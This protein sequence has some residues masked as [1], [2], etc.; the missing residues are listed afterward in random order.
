MKH[1]LNFMNKINFDIET[2]KIACKILEIKENTD[3]EHVKKAY[4]RAAVKYHP[5]H[6]SNK[7]E[8]NKRFKLIKCA[9]ELLAFDKPCD[10]IFEESSQ[11]LDIFKG[12]K[13]NLENNWGH[14]L[15]WKERFHSSSND[16]LRNNKNKYDKR[17]S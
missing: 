12:N 9:Y 7:V 6:S 3:I 17:K 16:E 8:A 2:R 5:D 14:F 1:D 10:K 13:Y 11:C 4:R 15:W